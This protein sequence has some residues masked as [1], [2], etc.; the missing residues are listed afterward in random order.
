MFF[1]FG[2]GD[3]DL[4]YSVVFYFGLPFLNRP[5]GFTVKGGMG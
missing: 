4:D 5:E 1:C 2:L 3:E